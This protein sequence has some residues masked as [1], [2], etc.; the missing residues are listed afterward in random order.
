MCA[1][2]AFYFAL[3]CGAELTIKDHYNLASNFYLDRDIKKAIFFHDTCCHKDSELLADYLL[4]G[5]NSGRN[6]LRNK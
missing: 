4:Y 6:S 5:K 2:R 3:A 1:S